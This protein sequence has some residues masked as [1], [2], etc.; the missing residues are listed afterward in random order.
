LGLNGCQWEFLVE[1]IL[2]ERNN[3]NKKAPPESYLGRAPAAPV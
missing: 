3:S 1:G 2:K